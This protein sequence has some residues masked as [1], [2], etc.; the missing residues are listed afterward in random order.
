MSTY[1]PTIKQLQ[2]LVALHEH[3]HFGRAADASFVS[4]STLS[5]GIR[6][7]ES[8]RRDVREMREKMRDTLGAGEADVFD[9]KQDAGGIVDIEFLVQFGVLSRAHACAGLTEW[10][11]VVRLLE[12]LA[13]AGFVTPDDAAFLKQAYCQ[14]RDRVHRAA[15]QETP[16]RAPASEFEAERSRVR[17]I[18]N[19]IMIG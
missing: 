11:D 15:L 13:T 18:W 8:L 3:G 4:Q 9:L 16:A 10:T 1:L 6:E 5:A 17:H 12:S 14:Y 19:A 2:Y 7:L